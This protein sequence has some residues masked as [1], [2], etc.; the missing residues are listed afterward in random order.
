MDGKFVV[1]CILDIGGDKILLY[2]EFFEEMNLFLGFC[3]ICFCFVN[4]EL[5]CI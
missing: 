4:E 1:V 2:L 3:V 5:F